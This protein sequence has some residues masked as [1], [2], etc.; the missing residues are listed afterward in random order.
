VAGAHIN[1]SVSPG[2]AFTGGLRT[3]TETYI[4]LKY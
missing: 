4:G 3:F 2:I 1:E